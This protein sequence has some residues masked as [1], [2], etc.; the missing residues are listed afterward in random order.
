[1]P[2]KNRWS[3]IRSITLAIV[4]ALVIRQFVLAFYAVDGNSMFPTLRNG[5]IIAVNKL[6]YKF[7]QPRRGDVIVFFLRESA[8][9]RGRIL[10]KRIIALPGD[11][12][13]IT[14]G[15]II[16]NGTPLQEDYINTPPAGD[17][18]PISLWEDMLFVMGDNRIP[19]GSWDSRDFGPIP[20][21]S[22]LGRASII[23]LPIPGKID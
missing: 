14:D 19:R 4:L 20:M 23:V 1:M 10:I 2:G 6:V 8:G 21:D 9:G 17:Y 11:T 22:V 5:Q 18:E 12:L 15:T 13:E 16:L 3:W 7:N